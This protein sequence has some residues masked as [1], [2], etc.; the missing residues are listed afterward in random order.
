MRVDMKRVLVFLSVIIIALGLC[1]CKS[2][3]SSKISDVKKALEE[4][5]NAKKAESEQYDKMVDTQYK[6]ED[7]AEEFKDGVFAEVKSK[8]R[9]YFGFHAVIDHSTV[10]SVFKYTKADP[11]SKSG[12]SVANMEVLVLQFTSG[13]NAQKYYD[14]LMASRKQ[15]YQNNEQLPAKIKNEFVEK[16]EYFAF[17]SESDYMTYNVYAS[18]DG[19]TVIYA[20]VEGPNADVLKAEYYEFMKKMECSVIKL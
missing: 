7:M 5:C 16:K 1:S 2:G 19:S 11:A 4:T 12:D 15:T 17:A 13:G 10:K 9:T 14:A 18:I 8:D 20:F 6:I 3:Y